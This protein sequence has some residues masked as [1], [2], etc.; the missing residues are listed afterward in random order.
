[1]MEVMRELVDNLWHH[2]RI[3]RLVV[4]LPFLEIIRK[5]EKSVLEHT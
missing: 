3:S 1:M 2:L 5:W 4:G